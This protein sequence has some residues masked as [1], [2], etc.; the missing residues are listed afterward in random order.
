MPRTRHRQSRP[1]VHTVLGGLVSGI[2]RTLLDW[3][4]HYLTH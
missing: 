3:I 1:T 2:T 4:L